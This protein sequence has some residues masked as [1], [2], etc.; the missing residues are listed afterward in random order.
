[1]LIDLSHDEA[2]LLFVLAGMSAKQLR[3]DAVAARMV[4]R[5]IDWDPDQAEIEAARMD[6]VAERLH[7]HLEASAFN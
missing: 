7:A 2:I 3:S 6:A 5:G 1:M 4:D